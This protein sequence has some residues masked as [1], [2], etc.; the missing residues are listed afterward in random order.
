M[1]LYENVDWEVIREELARVIEARGISE[2]Q[3]AQEIGIVH[4]TLGRLLS[5]ESGAPY[6]RTR[7][8]IAQWIAR[9]Q[10]AT[11]GGAPGSV[12][13][14]EDLVRTIIGD[15]N[16]LRRVLG[17]VPA[18][19]IKIRIAIIRQY[20]DVLIE[21]AVPPHRWPTWFN[22]IRDE[23]VSGGEKGGGEQT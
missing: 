22:E 1:H 11:H 8:A 21:N 17:V 4:T 15:P 9:H 6:T 2:Y 23:I 13:E 18:D 16:A 20:E 3:A 10:R 7:E 14:D 12:A 5:G 19:N